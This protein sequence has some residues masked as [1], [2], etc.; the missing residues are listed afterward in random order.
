MPSQLLM[1]YQNNAV[2]A[3]GQATMPNDLQLTIETSS[4]N[5]VSTSSSCNLQSTNNSST[6]LTTSTNSS[7]LDRSQQSAVSAEQHYL[8]AIADRSNNR[9][10]LL[11]YNSKSQQTNVINVFG[12]GPGKEPKNNLLP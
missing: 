12:S 1:N 5:S 10:Q 11:D 8:I 4:L 9:I 7:P 3:N 6:P 2:A